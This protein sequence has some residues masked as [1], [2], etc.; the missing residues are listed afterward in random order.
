MLAAPFHAWGRVGGSA[1]YSLYLDDTSFKQI[2]FIDL[3]VSIQSNAP[4]CL[5]SVNLTAMAGFAELGVVIR[6]NDFSNPLNL[7]I[8]TI[9]TSDIPSVRIDK[10][11]A[12]VWSNVATANIAYVAGATL[13]VDLKGSAI[14]VYYNNILA[15]VTT[16]N[17]AAI[18]NNPYSGMFSTLDGNRLDNFDII[19]NHDLSHL[20]LEKM[21]RRRNARL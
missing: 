20:T 14:R 9:V 8:A 7:L 18:L 10:C 16:N 1:S 6:M 2:P 21:T 4:D 13:V 15:F 12:G 17:D 11:L 5:I 3:I 19:P